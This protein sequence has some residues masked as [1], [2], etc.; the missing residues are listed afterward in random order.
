[1]NSNVINW[2]CV[3]CLNNEVS[4]RPKLLCKCPCK[5]RPTHISKSIDIIGML[6]QWWSAL[7]LELGNKTF[8]KQKEVV[9][10]LVMKSSEKK[11][12]GMTQK[13]KPSGLTNK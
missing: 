4:Q 3:N 12:K 2:S 9:R 7:I 11:K 6:A 1:M 13:A 8:L 5:T 10:P